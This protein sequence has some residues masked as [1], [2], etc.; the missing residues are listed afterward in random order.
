MAPDDLRLQSRPA[1]PAADVRKFASVAEIARLINSSNDLRAVLNRIVTAVC[2][3]SSW[4][5]CGI[6]SV[7]REAGLS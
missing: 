5:S 2:Q 6:M 3:H 7:N 4:A 1:V